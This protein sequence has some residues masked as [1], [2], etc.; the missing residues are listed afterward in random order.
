MKEIL[1][2]SYFYPPSGGP[3][4]Q[5]NLKLTKYLAK[6]NCNVSVLTTDIEAYKVIDK[7]LEEEIPKAV[8]VHRVKFNDY[9]KFFGKNKIFN[10]F[11]ALINVI[12]NLPDNKIFW[13]RKLYKEIDNIIL[14]EKIE[15]VIIS[16]P[17][18]STALLANYIKKKYNVQVI[19]DYRDP[20]LHSP[21][22]RFLPGYRAINRRL[23]NKVLNDVDGI[24]S[25]SE[26][27][28][29]KI[30]DEYRFNKKTTVIPNG[31][32]DEAILEKYITNNEKFTIT[33]IGNFSAKNNPTYLIE[34]ID[35]C[36][37]EGKI[38]KDKISLVFVGNNNA[39]AT[40]EYIKCTGYLP[41]NKIFNYTK[42]TD[43]LLLVLNSINNEGTYS[44][45][46]FEYIVSN[47]PILALVP[48]LGVAAELIRETKTG[49]IAEENN[50]N[51][52]KDVIVDIYNKWQ[53]KSLEITCDYEKISKYSRLELTKKLLEFIEDRNEV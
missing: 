17:P 34:A 10:K 2:I 53:N 26:P 36:I 5:R 16:I 44:G 25:V 41:H 33:F 30:K 48:K 40:R 39:Y 45:K 21:V 28:I 46:I 14:T 42:N 8:K 29:S 31:Y 7:A 18:Y 50:V 3:A 9:N 20:W 23:E 51:E 15:T 47:K 49:Y 27:I 11:L 24:I 19:I 4:V 1:L 12:L 37:R 13:T 6:L 52:I 38:N 22:Q 35:C 32:D 43:V